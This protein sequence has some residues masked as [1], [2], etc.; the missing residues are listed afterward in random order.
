MTY[1]HE[2]GKD[3]YDYM[4]LVQSLFAPS[5]GLQIVGELLGNSFFNSD[6]ILVVIKKK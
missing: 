2:E 1:I 6:I 5:F 4:Q 3:K